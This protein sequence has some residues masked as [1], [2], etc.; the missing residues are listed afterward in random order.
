M[1]LSSCTT[2]RLNTTS[3]PV[4]QVSRVGLLF[5]HALY[6]TIRLSTTSAKDTGVGNALFM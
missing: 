5:G 3:L 4:P 6:M 2:T 1:R